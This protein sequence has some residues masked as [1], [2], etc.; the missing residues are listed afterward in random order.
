MLQLYNLQLVAPKG[1][2]NMLD[3][4]NALRGFWGQFGIP[5]Y[6][7]GLAVVQSAPGRI[8]SAPL[9]YITFDY[10]VVDFAIEYGISARLWTQDPNP[11]ALSAGFTQIYWDTLGKIQKTIPPKSGTLVEIGDDA[12]RIW[13]TRG[14]PFVVHNV[15]DEQRTIKTA[16]ININIKIYQK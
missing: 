15:P 6:F 13:V 1:W 7:S 10:S 16:L 8:E 5:V 2:I 9:P 11:P 4:N 12:G 14:T 3:I